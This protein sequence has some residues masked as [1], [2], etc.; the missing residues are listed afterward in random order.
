MNNTRWIYKNNNIDKDIQNLGI[1]KDIVNILINRKIDKK[2]KIQNFFSSHLDKLKNPFSLADMQKS[3]DRVL[4]AIDNKELIYI[5]GDYDVDGI[6][7]TSISYLALKAL[8]ANVS[9]YIPLRDEGYGINN[10]ALKHIKEQGAK[11]V[12]SVDCGISSIKEALYAKELGLDLIITD[13]HEITSNLPEAYAIINPK[14][15]DQEYDFS[16]LA[17]CGT[18]FL[19]IMALYDT[20]GKKEETYKYIDI[21][22]IGTIADIVPLVEENRIIAKNGLEKLKNTENIGLSTLLP[23]VF[24]DYHNKEYTSY[25]VGF[26]IAPI[27]NAAGRLED[28]KRAVELLI[29]PSKE[30]AHSIALNLIE[31]NNERKELQKKYWKL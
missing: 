24:E 8:G 14:R 21:V 22:A 4:S 20:L 6:T 13:H 29:T 16:Y 5:Y 23:L 26:L 25:D 15:K 10:E 11:I 2:E 3:I 12:I 7:S 27:F 28:A 18:I 30:L 1:D 31:K 19:F 17:G 9:Y